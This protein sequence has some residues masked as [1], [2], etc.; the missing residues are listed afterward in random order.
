MTKIAIRDF[1]FIEE[2]TFLYESVS[3]DEKTVLGGYPSI[4][5]TNITDSIDGSSTTYES[6]GFHDNKIH[7]I[8]YSRSNYNWFGIFPKK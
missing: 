3:A 7:T 6:N 2:E 1:K 8:D 5:I 4:H